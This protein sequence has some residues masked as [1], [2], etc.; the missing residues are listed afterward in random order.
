M[1]STHFNNIILNISNLTINET[2]SYL[3]DNFN[4]II[5]LQPDGTNQIISSYIERIK[6]D[7]DINKN[8]Y[9]KINTFPYYETIYK[10]I[11]YIY[12]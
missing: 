8:N 4:D 2:K 6:Y 7:S 10:F 9:K 11:P 12:V 1:D 3:S 5:K